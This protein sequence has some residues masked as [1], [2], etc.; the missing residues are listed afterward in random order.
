MDEEQ[1]PE[2]EYWKAHN[3]KMR[4]MRDEREIMAQVN[5][6]VNKLSL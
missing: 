3:Q 1:D 6:W 5:Y 4:D 2:S